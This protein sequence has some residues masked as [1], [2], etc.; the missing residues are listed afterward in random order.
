MSSEQRLIMES[1]RDAT[2]SPR[3]WAFPWRAMALGLVCGNLVA[4]WILR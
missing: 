1:V 3:P 2:P 4:W